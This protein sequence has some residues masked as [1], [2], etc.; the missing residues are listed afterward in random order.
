[1]AGIRRRDQRIAIIALDAQPAEQQEAEPADVVDQRGAPDQAA[2]AAAKDAGE[3]MQLVQL[4][5]AF[6]SLGFEPA[7]RSALARAKA[8]R[9]RQPLG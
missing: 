9:R 7:L 5:G 2:L 4:R 3:I 1:M 6:E 8:R